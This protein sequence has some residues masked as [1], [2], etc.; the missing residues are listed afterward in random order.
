MAA[1][2]QSTESETASGRL[3]ARRVVGLWGII[4]ATGWIVTQLAI[5]TASTTETIQGGLTVF[6]LAGSLVPI[7]VSMLW[8]R[9][10]GFTGLFPVWTVLG[11]SG[12]V[13]SFAAIGGI[14]NVEDVFVF[15]SLWFAGPAV[16]FFTTGQYMNNWS[17]R[18]YNV[19][20]ILNLIAALGVVA[21]GFGTVYAAVAAVIQGGPMVYHALKMN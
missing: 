7:T 13:A 6:W 3:T 12:L 2:R 8:M 10:N 4:V 19:A 17:S 20:G 9:Q 14:V 16:G 21:P 5:L 11:V 18:L 1:T 15:G